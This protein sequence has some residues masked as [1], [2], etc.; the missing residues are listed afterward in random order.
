MRGVRAIARAGYRCPAAQTVAECFAATPRHAFDEVWSPLCIAALNTPPA[1]A[2]AQV[3]AT[4]LRDA[5]GARAADSDFLVPACD[6]SALFPD[7]AARYVAARGGDVRTGVAVRGVR[8]GAA[9]VGV[10]TAAGEERFAAAIVAVGP[11]Q[12]AAT[13]EDERVRSDGDDPWR[14]ALVARRGLCLRIDHDRVSRVS[15]RPSRCRRAIARLDDAPGQWVFDRSGALAGAASGAARALLAVVISANGPHDTPGPRD[16]G[17]VDRRAA[18]AA[19][20]RRCRRR[21]G[22]A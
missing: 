7:A 8:P 13:V 21:C 16:A 19:V 4:V 11:H 5:F 17:R 14:D 22:R 12:L 15:A 20:A 3:F 10:R 9:D 1:R 6:L 18:A 2:S